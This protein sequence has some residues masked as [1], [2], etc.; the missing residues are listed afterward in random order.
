MTVTLIQNASW[1]VA[2]D[3][4]AKGHVYLRDGDVAYEDNRLIHVGGTY[5]GKPDQTIDGRGKM[6]MP[7]LVNIHSHPSSEAMTKG[8]ND[9]LGSAKMYGTALYEFMPLFRCDAQGHQALR[10]GHLFRAAD[11]GRDHAG[12]HVGRLGWLAR[13]LQGVGPARRV[14]AD[15]PL[16]ALV[17]R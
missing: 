14:L 8:W 15:V 1:I 13:D 12:R 9:E 4:K 2:Y 3:A 7:G 17:H 11:V 5:K 16:G 6:V 10:A